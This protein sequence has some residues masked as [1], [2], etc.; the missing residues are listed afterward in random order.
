MDIVLSAKPYGFLSGQATSLP[1]EKV[2]S[3]HFRECGQGIVVA[4]I[5]TATAN[6]R[7]GYSIVE[8]AVCPTQ[9]MSFED[10]MGHI[11]E[12]GDRLWGQRMPCELRICFVPMD[13]LI[14]QIRKTGNQL[15]EF[16]A[17]AADSS[18]VTRI[19]VNPSSVLHVQDA[20]NGQSTLRLNALSPFSGLGCRTIHVPGP[21]DEVVSKIQAAGGSPHY[22]A[23]WNRQLAELVA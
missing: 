6:I 21:K 7:G 15:V 9:S 5:G 1:A 4:T 16:Q 20:G 2:Q 17:R 11:Q 23:T 19:F 18:D 13:D 22:P 12:R 10:I 3:I 8:T 14:A